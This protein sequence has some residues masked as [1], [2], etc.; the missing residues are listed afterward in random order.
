MDYYDKYAKFN[1]LSAKMTGYFAAKAIYDNSIPLK[2]RTE[3]LNFLIKVWTDSEENDF[4]VQS[5]IEQW[6]KDIKEISA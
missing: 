4:L 2:A 3:M 6:Q 1:A 5:W